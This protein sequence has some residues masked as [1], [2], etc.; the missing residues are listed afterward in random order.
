MENMRHIC[1]RPK[2]ARIRNGFPKSVMVRVRTLESFF[3]CV[4]SNDVGYNCKFQLAYG[5]GRQGSSQIVARLLTSYS[6]TH[7]FAVLEQLPNQR[8]GNVA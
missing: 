3:E 6:R 5:G 1:S 2:K 4:G 8:S 7:T